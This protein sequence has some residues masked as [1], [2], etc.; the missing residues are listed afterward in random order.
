[1]QSNRGE[2][3]GDLTVGAH[4]HEVPSEGHAADSTDTPYAL[5]REDLI[6]SLLSSTLVIGLFLDG[7]NHINLLHGRLGS[8]FTPWHAMLYAGFALSA[9]WVLTRNPHLYLR[10]KT[11]KPELFRLFGIPLRYPFAVAGIA[12][13]VVGVGGDLI[14]HTV[15]GAETGVARVIAP[16]HLMLFSGGAALIAAAFRSG[17]HAP[18]HYPAVIGFKQ[19]LPP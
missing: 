13:A 10:G 14:W 19:F 1:M 15:F 3:M 7:W 8:F 9:S 6:A 16:F 17:W 18:R 2:R 11:S 4:S 5:W 12:L